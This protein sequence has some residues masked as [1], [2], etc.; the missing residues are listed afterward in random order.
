MA[1]IAGLV[2]VFV[3]LARGQA[4]VAFLGSSAWLAGML[5]A[6]ASCLFPVLLRALPD[7]ALSITAYNG[8]NT[9]AGLRT[10]LGWWAV[11]FPIAAA[12]FVVLFRIHRGKAVAARDG[13]GY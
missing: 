3:G 11:G 9:A 6:T 2:A 8:G 13:E 4:L 7:P 1:A 5:V 12:Y 10:A